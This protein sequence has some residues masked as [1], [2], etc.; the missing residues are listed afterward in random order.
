VGRRRYLPQERLLGLPGEPSLHRVCGARS[1]R[2]EFGY[3]K[4]CADT[5]YRV[6]RERHWLERPEI[7]WP[8]CC[9]AQR[10]PAP[11]FA[12][13]RYD[14]PF[15]VLPPITAYKYCNVF[16]C[17]FGMDRHLWDGLGRDMFSGSILRLDDD[18]IRANCHPLFMFSRIF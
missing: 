16:S 8:E 7:H 17:G 14:E 12:V 18:A 13:L 2:T 11:R 9:I 1:R 5:N 4:W 10:E 15:S 3:R 6:R